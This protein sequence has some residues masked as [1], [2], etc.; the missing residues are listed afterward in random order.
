V[1]TARLCVCAVFGGPQGTVSE[2]DAAKGAAK[3]ATD[4]YTAL[5]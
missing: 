4:K 2:Y 5:K 1:L 3:E